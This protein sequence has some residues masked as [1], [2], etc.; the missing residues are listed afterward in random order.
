MAKT[1][2]DKNDGFPPLAALSLWNSVRLE[3]LVQSSPMFDP[4]VPLHYPEVS[5]ERL[6]T[7]QQGSA[8]RQ[9]AGRNKIFRIQHG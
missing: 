7:Q 4:L 3:D 5:N 2:R 1:V 8:Q 6:Y 9:D